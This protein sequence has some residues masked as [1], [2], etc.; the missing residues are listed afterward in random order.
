MG[1]SPFHTQITCILIR[2]INI[3]ISTIVEAWLAVWPRE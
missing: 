3:G 1:N 2:K